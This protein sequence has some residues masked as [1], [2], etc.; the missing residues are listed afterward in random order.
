MPDVVERCVQ[1]DAAPSEV[2]EA[3]VDPDRLGEWLNVDVEM[4]TQP[5]GAARF[6]RPDGTRLLGVVEEVVPE[7]RLSFCWWPSPGFGRTSRVEISLEEGDAGTEVRVVETF[8]S[9]APPKRPQ[10]RVLASV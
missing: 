8:L 1:V 4:D 6:V 2:W 7:R 3:V 9:V 10:L 5:G